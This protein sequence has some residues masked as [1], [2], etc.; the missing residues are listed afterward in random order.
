MMILA[1]AQQVHRSY[2]GDLIV[3]GPE[4]RTPRAGGVWQS[5]ETIQR[6]NDYVPRRAR[7]HYFHDSTL[8]PRTPLFSIAQTQI[9]LY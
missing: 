9:F 8:A 6:R 7:A 1:Y 5:N 4:Q 3:V 2:Q